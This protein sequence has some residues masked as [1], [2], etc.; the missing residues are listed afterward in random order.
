MLI[1]PALCFFYFLFFNNIEDGYKKRAAG[2]RK[3]IA[4]VSVALTSRRIINRFL[5]C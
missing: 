1:S 5:V 4:A 2:K 3:P